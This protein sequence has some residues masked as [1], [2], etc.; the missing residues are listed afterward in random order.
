MPELLIA[1]ADA[2]DVTFWVVIALLFLIF[3]R[4]DSGK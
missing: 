4:G 2:A 1:G 3:F